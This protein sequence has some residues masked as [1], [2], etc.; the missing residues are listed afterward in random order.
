MP[1]SA[2]LDLLQLLEEGADWCARWEGSAN[3]L[4]EALRAGDFSVLMAVTA[5]QA[6][7]A[8]FF[9]Q[10]EAE[11][12]RL[13]ARIG[14]AGDGGQQATS[15]TNQSSLCKQLVPGGGRCR[16]LPFG[17]CQQPP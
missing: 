17:V 7:L 1:D 13:Q 6:R 3:Q 15:Q 10:F 16:Q 4:F 14:Q 12:R 5:E 11:R 9:G 8:A 2:E